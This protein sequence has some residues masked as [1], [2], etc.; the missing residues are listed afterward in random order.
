MP[1]AGGHLVRFFAPSSIIRTFS[2]QHCLPHPVF[3]NR[4]QTR[5]MCKPLPSDSFF[6]FPPHVDRFFPFYSKKAVSGVLKL[7]AVSVLC[8]SSLYLQE[9]SPTSATFFSH[10]LS[11]SLVCTRCSPPPS[12]HIFLAS[13]HIPEVCTRFCRSNT[14]SCNLVFSSP[15]PS[16]SPL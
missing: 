13:F 5:T 9:C 14:L 6:L 2:C 11:R 4:K 10:E 16:T 15:P 7:A 1:E 8:P 12:H 3:R